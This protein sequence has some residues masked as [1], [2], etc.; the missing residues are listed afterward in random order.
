MKID[1]AT[2]NKLIRAY[3]DV[4]WEAFVREWQVGVKKQVG[5]S[6]VKRMGGGGDLGRDVVGLCGADGF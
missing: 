3:N 4:E 5:Y 2:A 6:E 1:I